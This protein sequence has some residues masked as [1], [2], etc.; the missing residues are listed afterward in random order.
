[1]VVLVHKEDAMRWQRFAV[2]VTALNFVLLG[3]GESSYVQ[4]LARGPNPFAKLINKDG[5][6]QL[7]KPEG[8]PPPK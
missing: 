4:I 7:I 3:G 8:Q 2:V 1:V 6:Q 5:R